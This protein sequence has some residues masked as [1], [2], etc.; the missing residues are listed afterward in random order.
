MQRLHLQDFIRRMD[1]ASCRQPS[2]GLKVTHLELRDLGKRHLET[3]GESDEG[4]RSLVHYLDSLAECIH[5]KARSSVRLAAEGLQRRW[6]FDV[7]R[8]ELEQS[9]QPTDAGTVYETAK[10]NHPRYQ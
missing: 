5:P 10:K 1:E 4:V 3:Y 6:E 2:Y 9:G 7:A 8:R